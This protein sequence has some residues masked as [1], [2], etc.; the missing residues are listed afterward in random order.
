MGARADLTP[1]PTGVESQVESVLNSLP[2]DID[3]QVRSMMER[4]KNRNQKTFVCKVCGK[5]AEHSSIR[6]GQKF[7]Q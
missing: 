4:T 1:L 5:E 2:S 7:R 6:Y 3:R